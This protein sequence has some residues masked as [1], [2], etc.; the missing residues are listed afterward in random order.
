MG[1]SCSWVCIH[2]R[3]LVGMVYKRKIQ[4]LGYKAGIAAY[5]EGVKASRIQHL[6]LQFPTLCLVCILVSGSI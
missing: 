4:T 6:F 5:K 1:I 2:I 3:T